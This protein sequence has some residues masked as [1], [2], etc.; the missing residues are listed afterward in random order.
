MIATASRKPTKVS[1]YLERRDYLSY[2]AIT[3]FQKCPLAFR[4]RYLDGLRDETTS[5]SLAVGRSVHAAIEAWFTARMLGDPEP[6]LDAM[7]SAFWDEWRCCNEDTPVKFGKNEDV[8]SI[9][10]L[11]RRVLTA[12]VAID[13][14]RPDGWIVGIEEEL[15]GPLIDG[16]PDL[17]GRIDLI[18]ETDKEL[19]IVDW[20]TSRSKWSVEQTEQA[21]GQLLLYGELA[22]EMSPFKPVRLMYGVIAKTKVPSIEMRTVANDSQKGISN[23]LDDQTRMV[24][25]RAAKLLS[26]S[27]DDEL[28]D[29]SIS[30][31]VQQLARLTSSKRSTPHIKKGSNSMES[32]LTIACI[33]G[34]AS[35]AYKYGKR[36]GSK[37]A[38]KVGWRRGRSRRLTKRRR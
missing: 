26:L 29:L 31:T 15:R 9:D 38:F 14:A 5:S 22:K 28:R 34:L 27:V 1:Q 37:A 11:A 16:V 25:H 6:G 24:S 20:K 8:K 30:R 7:L 12:F 36:D 19:V 21:A 4:F 32:V 23:D 3:L 2:S 10:D 18:T 33:I 35:W 13:A 17:L